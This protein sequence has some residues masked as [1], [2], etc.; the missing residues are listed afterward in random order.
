MKQLIKTKLINK[1]SDLNN[2]NKDLI[3]VI[4]TNDSTSGLTLNLVNPVC[5]PNPNCNNCCQSCSTFN[6]CSQKKSGNFIY[7][8]GVYASDKIVN[9]GNGVTLPKT[10]NNL[11]NEKSGYY[12]IKY[13]LQ[14]QALWAIPLLLNIP[15][16]LINNGTLFGSI[17]I[18]ID[19]TNNILVT[20]TYTSSSAVNLGNGYYLKPTPT[21][22]SVFII[23]YNSQ[24]VI[25]W[26]KSIFAESGISG[27]QVSAITTDS[28]NNVLITGTYKINDTFIPYII[29]Y[30]SQGNLQWEK[31][32][33]KPSVNDQ[34]GKGITTDS[35]NNV[36]VTGYYGLENFVYICF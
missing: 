12:I 28:A 16:Q 11:S 17:F 7:T 33:G 27:T 1:H 25:Q 15:P 24:R 30:N 29:K 5:N 18:S 31:S 14:N 22:G 10:T 19:S 3:P 35:A 26:A 9:L 4:T 23:K 8:G 36:L 21:V 13:N 34:S 32:I 6:Q 20:G 2:K